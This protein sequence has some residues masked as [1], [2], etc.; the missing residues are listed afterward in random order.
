MSLILKSLS[1]LVIKQAA[2]NGGLVLLIL[3]AIIAL[4]VFIVIRINKAIS[5]DKKQEKQQHKIIQLFTAC[6]C[7]SKKNATWLQDPA[8]NGGQ[9]PEPVTCKYRE[10][11]G[12]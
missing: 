11:L 6:P 2:E 7:V 1:E 4:A 12:E 5:K 8:R 3:G 10:D 9:P